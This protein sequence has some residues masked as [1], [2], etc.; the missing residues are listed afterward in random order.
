MKHSDRN[1]TCSFEGV[2]SSKDFLFSNFII[3]TEAMVVKND[4]AHFFR[5]N[6]NM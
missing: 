5:C 1:T 6:N 4:L 2:I 3:L